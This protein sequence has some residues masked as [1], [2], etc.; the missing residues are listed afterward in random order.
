M[1]CAECG[2]ASSYWLCSNACAL[3]YAKK[4]ARFECAVCSYDPKTGR[5]GRHDTTRLC[6]ECRGREE[7]AV[8]LHRDE[9]T[10]DMRI[11]EQHEGLS[12]LREQQDRPLPRVTPLM[13]R[14]VLKLVEG[15]TVAIRY[16]DRKGVS[17]GTRHRQQPW[18]ARELAAE[19]GCTEQAVRRVLRRLE[20]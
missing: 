14:V 1:T 3:T 16:R 7:N 13:R 8:W 5:V 19:L 10:P 17:R 6:D 11:D 4:R 15:R 9:E 20:M 18:S 2:K 12:R